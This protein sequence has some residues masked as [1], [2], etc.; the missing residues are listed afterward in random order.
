MSTITFNDYP[1]EL[2]AAV[3]A[4]DEARRGT[5]S[6]NRLTGCGEPAMSDANK[7]TIAPMI[8]TAVR[9]YIEVTV[10]R[11]PAVNAHNIRQIFTPADACASDVAWV[12][13][14]NPGEDK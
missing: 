9:A 1:P 3:N 11:Y 10:Q 5:A 14:E 13:H 2:Q 7:A 6:S 4:Y 8:M 12:A